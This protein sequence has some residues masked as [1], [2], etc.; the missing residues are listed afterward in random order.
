MTGVRPFGLLRWH[1]L[2][3]WCLTCVGGTAAIFSATLATA[4]P[5][6]LA[7]IA[8][9]NE[10]EASLVRALESLKTDGIKPA[11]R[12]L[13]ATLAKN[14]NFRLGHLIKGVKKNEK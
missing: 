14:P 7:S 12:E 11:L 9:S 5:A 13:D 10:V 1:S 8:F 6:P 4:Q 3:A 2:T